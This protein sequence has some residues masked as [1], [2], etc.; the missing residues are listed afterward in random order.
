MAHP[1]AA[2]APPGVPITGHRGGA[3]EKRGGGRAGDSRS[4]RER[5]RRSATEPAPAGRPRSRPPPSQCCPVCQSMP[6]TNGPPAAGYIPPDPACALCG[7]CGAVRTPALAQA[8]KHAILVV[9]VV[10]VTIVG[11]GSASPHKCDHGGLS[12]VNDGCAE[13]WWSVRQARPRTAISAMAA[14]VPG[15]GERQAVSLR[16]QA[17]WREP[18]PR[19]CELRDC[20]TGVDP[21][22]FRE[23]SPPRNSKACRTRMLM[24]RPWLG[25][26]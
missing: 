21:D 16:G 24:R 1:A 19:G 5:P 9:L 17:R 11:P 13:D 15:S 6:Q 26:P 8:W 18:V 7:C 10:V 20:R 3:G 22:V 25:S 4:P 12:C 2:H 23:M 14:R